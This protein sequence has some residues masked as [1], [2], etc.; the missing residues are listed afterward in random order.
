LSPFLG[1]R[2]RAAHLLERPVFIRELLPQD[3]KLEIERL[4]EKEATKAARFLASVVGYAHARQMDSATRSAWREELGK[5]R[6]EALDAPSW[7][8]SSVVALLVNHEGEYLEH[9]R[10]YAIETPG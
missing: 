3:L 6:S 8:W 9:C 4:S 2:M 5:H 10:R 1:E 7:L